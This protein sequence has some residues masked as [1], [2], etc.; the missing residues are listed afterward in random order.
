MKREEVQKK[1]ESTEQDLCVVC[2]RETEFKKNVPI[3]QRVHY[4]VGVGQ[5]CCKCWKELY[6]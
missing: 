4:I 5:L 2:W 1:E 6:E 3:N